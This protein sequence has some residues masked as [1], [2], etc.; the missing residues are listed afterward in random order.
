MFFGELNFTTE[1]PT[2]SGY[3][4]VIWNKNEEKLLLWIDYTV[5]NG[6]KLWFWRYTQTDEPIDINFDA[7]NTEH[8]QFSE[9]IHT[10]DE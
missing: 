8:P 5:T 7:H 3:Y 2:E 4:F 1:K 9:R 6:E 10:S